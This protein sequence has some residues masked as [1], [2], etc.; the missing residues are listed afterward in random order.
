MMMKMMIMN[1]SRR[2]LAMND[3][4]LLKDLELTDA[5]IAELE[6]QSVLQAPLLSPEQ[7]AR[8]LARLYEMAAKALEEPVVARKPIIY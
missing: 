6:A 4:D 7:N 8:N 1:R 2:S 5:D 3:D